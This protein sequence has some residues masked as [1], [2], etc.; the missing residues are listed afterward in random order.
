[1]VKCCL[2][3]FCCNLILGVNLWNVDLEKFMGCLVFF[4]LGGGVRGVI[5]VLDVV[6]LVFVIGFLGVV[7]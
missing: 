7:F 3:D 4:E 2:E 1:M 5:F 6:E